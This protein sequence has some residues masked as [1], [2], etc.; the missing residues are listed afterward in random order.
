[1]TW[2]SAAPDEPAT[3]PAEPS[4]AESLRA[5]HNRATDVQGT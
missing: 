5:E 2:L 4:G 3:G 1:M